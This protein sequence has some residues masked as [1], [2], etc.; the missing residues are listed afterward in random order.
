[1]TTVELGGT[2]LADTDE[3]T[4]VL[5]ALREVASRP[6]NDAT[7]TETDAIGQVKAF[8]EWLDDKRPEFANSI[9]EEDKFARLVEIARKYEECS[10]FFLNEVG[11]NAATVWRWA[12]DKSRPSKFVGKRIVAEI[13]PLLADV[14][15]QLCYDRGLVAATSSPLRRAVSS[16]KSALFGA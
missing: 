14:L 9:G 6:F 15:W 1:M 8:V 12:N 5:A 4:R 7:S 16:V 11:V 2:Y 3:G 13:K 10:S